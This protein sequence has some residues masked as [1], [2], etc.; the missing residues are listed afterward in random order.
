M[1]RI[2]ME[3][4]GFGILNFIYIHNRN[5]KRSALSS[6]TA[7]RPFLQVFIIVT[8]LFP[9]KQVSWRTEFLWTITR[10]PP[11]F[12]LHRRQ[13]LAGCIMNIA[14]KRR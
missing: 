14:W 6:R 3:F 10:Y 13:F 5:L 1:A 7:A 11:V 4:G 8:N 12:E 2:S 9:D